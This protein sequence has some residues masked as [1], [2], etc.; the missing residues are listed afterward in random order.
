MPRYAAIDIGSNSVRMLA[1]ETSPGMPSKILAAERQVTRLGAGVFQNGR[2][3]PQATAFVCE[4]LVRMAQIYR[5]LE[6]VG[7]RAVATSAVRDA[8]DQHEFIEKASNALGSPVEII[9]GP[10]E[11]RLIHLGVQ[12]RW[13]HPDK[14]VLI[15]DVGGGSAEVILGD[16]GALSEAFSKPLGALR[17][18]EVFLKSDPPASAELHRLNDYIEEKLA[19][20]LRRVGTGV[21]DRAIAT[22]ATA[23]AMV[24]A[25]NRVGRSR[26]EE[27]DRLKASI[28]QVRR[29][30]RE[31]SQLELAKRLKIQGI[32]PRRAELIIAGAAVFLKFLELFRQPCLHYSA[33]GVRDGIIADLAARGVGRE[34]SMLNREQRRVV[35][36]MARRYGVDLGHARRVAQLAHRLFESLQQVHRLPPPLGKLLEASAYLHDIGHYVSASAHHKHSYYLVAHSDLPGFT[37][38]ER[39][40]IALLCRYHR[41]AL[42]AAR[43]TPFQSF[44]ADSRRAITLLTPLLRIA[45]SLD[46]S[47][48]QRVSGIDVQLRNGSVNITL[49]SD[50]DPDLELWAVERIA[51]AFRDTYQM[52]LTL[53]RSKS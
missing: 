45:D 31:V 23:A 48:E 22:S 40:M 21:F 50:T 16:R 37:D 18:T 32:G 17:L 7:V 42:P 9:S 39:Q 4:H 20:P 47:H 11:A 36:Q 13:P 8:A 34:L 29:F 24:C 3:A 6:V 2:I 33:A 12:A 49:D 25:V 5:E 26:R 19:T 41:K 35:E 52:P 1:A 38:T 15:V 44:N 30:Y 14:R 53:A 51:D 46:R 28:G 27:A 10:E 43:H